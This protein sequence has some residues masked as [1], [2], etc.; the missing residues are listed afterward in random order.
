MAVNLT[1]LGAATT[2]ASALAGLALVSPQGTQ[3]YRPQSPP[4]T[5]GF[6]SFSLSFAGPSLLFHYEGENTAVIESDITDHYTET[7]S[8]VQDQIALK[9]EVITVHGFIGELN[10]VPPFFLAPLKTAADKLT[11]VSAYLPAISTTAQIAYNAAFQAYQA[12][13]SLVSTGTSAWNL[14]S[15]SG[16][17]NVIGDAGLGGAF[18]ASTG[19]VSNNQNKQQTMFQQFYG[20]WSARTLFTV[21]TPWAVFSNM[22][23]L[24]MRAIQDDG[25][26]VITDFEITFKKI[27]YVSTAASAA[28]YAARLAEQ[29][30]TTTA[31]GVNG[32]QTTNSFGSSVDASAG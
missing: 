20:Y 31:L 21:Q 9:P 16:G 4:N 6:P 5:L 32:L 29:A 22:A 2:T 1:S 19:Q 8:A 17:E 23:I 15:G 7:N 14:L 24:R 30:S 18:N 10:D 13:A 3:G 27:R 11:V 26:N 28:A 25:T 12:A